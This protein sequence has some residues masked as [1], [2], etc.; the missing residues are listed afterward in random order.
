[1]RGGY[2]GVARRRFSASEEKGVEDSVVA[3]RQLAFVRSLL[4]FYRARCHV[5]QIP[6][7]LGRNFAR[8]IF[9]YRALYFRVS[10]QALSAYFL[11]YNILEKMLHM[12]SWKF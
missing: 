8:W 6:S 9:F 2:R 11:S 1:M 4:F 5:R 3:E 10:V 7:A 12:D